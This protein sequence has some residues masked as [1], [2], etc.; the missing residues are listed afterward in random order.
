MNAW[1]TDLISLA[2]QHI[3][4]NWGGHG[5]CVCVGEGD[6][7]AEVQAKGVEGAFRQIISESLIGNQSSY[8]LS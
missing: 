7:K 3:G 2:V 5:V 8:F 6:Y 1:A 4:K